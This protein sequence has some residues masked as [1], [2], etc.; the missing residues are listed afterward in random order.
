MGEIEKRVKELVGRHFEV[1]ASGCTLLS[2]T[3]NGSRRSYVFSGGDRV[4]AKLS[5]GRTLADVTDEI[6]LTNDVRLRGFPFVCEFLK[7]RDGSSGIVS[8]V[9]TISVYRYVEGIVNQPLTDA[10][11]GNLILCLRD[12]LEIIKTTTVGR[13]RNRPFEKIEDSFKRAS[14]VCKRFGVLPEIYPVLSDRNLV[15]VCAFSQE[16]GIIH[17]DL[18]SGNFVWNTDDS[19]CAVLDFERFGP[20]SPALEIAALISGSC[21]A[22]TRLLRERIVRVVDV[23]TPFIRESIA[24]IEDVIDLAIAVA[25]Y[26]FAHVNQ[27]SITDQSV[28]GRCELRDALR[29]LELFE[30]RDQL[31]E[32]IRTGI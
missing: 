30:E 9:G 26:Y 32:A 20:G 1:D 22:G 16:I 13:R 25:L 23:A 15:Q 10:Q 11:F 27:H 8:E 5:A 14:Q 4:V 24:A 7:T 31:K 12:Y 21:F 6:E 2:S 3:G 18:H 19:L 28:A 29:A 17:S